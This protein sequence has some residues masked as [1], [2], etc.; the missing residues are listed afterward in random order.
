M[1]INSYVFKKTEYTRVLQA[2]HEL[3]QTNHSTTTNLSK[4]LGYDM[5]G[6]HLSK[7]LGNM[8]RHNLITR[9]KRGNGNIG[10]P[11]T[12]I[13]VNWE[14]IQKQLALWCVDGEEETIPKTLEEKRPELNKQIIK[15]TLTRLLEHKLT[16]KHKIQLTLNELLSELFHNAELLVP[17]FSGEEVEAWMY[18]HYLY[19]AHKLPNPFIVK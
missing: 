12:T 9:E 5:E 18:Y 6:R 8:K 10:R 15:Q 11:R 7:L 13:Q 19:H 16:K 1:A 17:L 14:G 3:E 4:Q 2:I